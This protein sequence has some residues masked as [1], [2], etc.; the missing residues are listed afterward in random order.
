[1]LFYSPIKEV[2]WYGKKAFVV[3]LKNATHPSKPE[4]EDGCIR[5]YNGGNIYL[6]VEDEHEPEAA[7]KTFCL[8]N[9]NYNGWL[10]NFERVMARIV[11]RAFNK[12]QE[13]MIKGYKML[14]AKE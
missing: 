5:A 14:Y 9:N 4:G 2:D 10:P 8:T 7:C 13:N 11:P 12:L 1:M 3:I 6:A